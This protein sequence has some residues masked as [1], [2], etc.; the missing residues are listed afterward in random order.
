MDASLK[1]AGTNV[2]NE[3][4]PDQGIKIHQTKAKDLKDGDIVHLLTKKPNKYGVSEVPF[5]VLMVDGKITLEEV[6]EVDS[7]DA[8]QRKELARSIVAAHREEIM[9]QAVQATEEALSRKPV[10]KLQALKE[11]G[12]T[13]KAKVST[14]KGCMFL[15]FGPE[16]TLL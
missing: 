13:N 11:K 14:K 3:V 1:I 12:K 7:S 2:E 4:P 8:E 15:E 16:Q 10:E 6:K 9:E 5:K